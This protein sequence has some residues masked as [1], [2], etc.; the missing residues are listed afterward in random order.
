MGSNIELDTAGVHAQISLIGDLDICG[1]VLKNCLV[2][3]ATNTSLLAPVRIA[4]QGWISE[5]GVTGV[6]RHRD[7]KIHLERDEDLFWIHDGCSQH[8]VIPK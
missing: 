3:E 2:N 4:D 8:T 5:T 6:L 7:R 1:L